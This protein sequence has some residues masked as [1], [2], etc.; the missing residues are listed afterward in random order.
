MHGPI[1]RVS[2]LFPLDYFGSAYVFT[3]FFLFLGFYTKMV[4]TFGFV[5]G[6]SVGWI[7][8]LIT[9]LI[10]AIALPLVWAYA[11]YVIF[12]T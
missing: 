8:A 1:S 10:I 3:A 9:S 4:V 11:G 12:F 2:H 5:I 7:P 6:L